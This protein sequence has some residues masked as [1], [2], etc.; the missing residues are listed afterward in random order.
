MSKS[1]EVH[2]LQDR[3]E[4]WLDPKASDTIEMGSWRRVVHT[5]L[6]EIAFLG[7]PVCLVENR[8]RGPSTLPDLAKDLGVRLYDDRDELIACIE[9]CP[10]R[11]IDLAIEDGEYEIGLLWFAAA[12]G[13]DRLHEYFDATAAKREPPFDAELMHVHSDGAVV[14]WWHPSREAEVVIERLRRAPI[15]HDTAITLIR[16]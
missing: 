2:V 8:Y 11:A 9:R 6:L 12:H 14:V 4:F 1:L 16:E 7:R 3:A 13:P 10:E 15:G 5:A